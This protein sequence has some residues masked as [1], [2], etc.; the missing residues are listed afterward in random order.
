MDLAIK[1]KC[2]FLSL[3]YEFDLVFF[4]SKDINNFI[5][6]NVTTDSCVKDCGNGICSRNGT[7]SCDVGFKGESCNQIIEIGNCVLLVFSCVSAKDALSTR[8]VF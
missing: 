1:M 7:C 2:Y 8:E 3:Y 6:S 5:S 4:S